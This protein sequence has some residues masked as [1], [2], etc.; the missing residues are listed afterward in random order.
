MIPLTRLIG[1]FV[2][3]PRYDEIPAAAVRTVCNGFTDV[4]ACIVLGRDMP[5]ARAVMQV[6]NLTP[7][8]EA[9]VCFGPL[10]ANAPEAAL[11][12]GTSAHA[13]DY[14]DVGIGAHPAHPSA[15][16]APAIL[17]EA[18]V[19]RRSGRDM[20]AAYV[21]G[22][23]VWGE[24]ARRDADPHN[25]RGFHPTGVFG[26]LAAAAACAKLRG[27]D[28]RAASN[29]IGIAA[30]QAG[31]LVANFG[32]MAKPFQAGHPAMVGVRSA[33]LAAAG[34]DAKADVIEQG[35]LPAV[36]PRG[37]V[38]LESPPI[39]GREWWTVTNGLGFKLFPMCYG[40]HRSLD[41]MLQLMAETPTAP[42]QVAGIDVEMSPNQQI[43]LINHDPQT[44]LQAKF[45]EEF[46]MAM[47]VIAKRATMTEV[48]DSF[49]QRPDVRALMKKVRITTIPG[50]GDDRPSTPPND[51]V[52]V[53]LNDGRKL[54]RRFDNPRGHPRKPVDGDVMW[55]KFSD[56]VIDAM[57]PAAAR[58][59]FDK[60]QSLDRLP[61]VRDLPLIAQADR[62]KAPKV[63][64][65]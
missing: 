1:E 28:A 57:P 42:E 43:N 26:A 59:M 17:A 10:G 7:G 21:A 36:S 24:L 3:G 29:A 16:L 13:L 61:S 2:A 31:G 34:M 6:S 60:L 5:V 44:G 8:G 22:Y 27:L 37:R 4:S 48:S 25:M 49:V 20:I 39:F 45:S 55:M 19:L 33:R 58:E 65:V 50:V 51:G 56:C 35:F 41:G 12:N 30:S 52:T 63:R 54:T 38:D 14:D 40:T 15:V 46:A 53:T 64:V 32:S 62:S 18:E 11:I 23:E 9:R 47:A